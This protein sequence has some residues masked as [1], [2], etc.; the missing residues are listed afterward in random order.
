MEKHGD[1]NQGE[2]LVD[3]KSK[4]QL[5]NSPKRDKRKINDEIHN[6]KI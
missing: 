2:N 1:S 6:L 3:V 4:V 5:S